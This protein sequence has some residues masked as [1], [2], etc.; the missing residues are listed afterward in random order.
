[1]HACKPTLS[2]AT[3]LEY[4]K[5]KKITREMHANSKNALLDLVKGMFRELCQ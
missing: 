4:L 3:F 2:A 5:D 1:M